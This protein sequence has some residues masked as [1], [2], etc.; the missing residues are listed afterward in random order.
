MFEKTDKQLKIIRN[1]LYN[2]MS[3][4]SE[5]YYC[6]GW[7]IN[8]EYECWQRF[9]EGRFTPEEKYVLDLLRHEA[10]GWMKFDYEF[11]PWD[12]WIE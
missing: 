6:A 3:D 2:F 12:L 7:M 9:L 5:E 10:G 11:V 1:A 4:L 8:W